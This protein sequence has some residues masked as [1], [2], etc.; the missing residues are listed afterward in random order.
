MSVLVAC[1][2]PSVDPR[3]EYDD[4]YDDD[5]VDFDLFD[6]PETIGEVDW[7]EDDDLDGY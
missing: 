6:D 4:E 1:N 3:D 5:E 7:E 2:D